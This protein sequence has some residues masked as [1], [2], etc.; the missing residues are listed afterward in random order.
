MCIE[1]FSFDQLGSAGISDLFNFHKDIG[2]VSFTP[3]S[4]DFFF[5]IFTKDREKPFA[6]RKTL[7]RQSYSELAR[8]TQAQIHKTTFSRVRSRL[9]QQTEET[10]A[11]HRQFKYRLALGYRTTRGSA[12]VSFFNAA[13]VD[14]R[15]LSLLR[16]PLNRLHRIF[17]KTMQASVWVSQHLFCG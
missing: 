8:D 13:L 1:L 3:F 14:C 16:M 10:E 9:T 11:W 4:C 6:W 17:P 15:W 5:V 7:R 12:L 2:K